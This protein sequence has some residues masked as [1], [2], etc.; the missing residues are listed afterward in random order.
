MLETLNLTASV[1]GTN[2]RPAWRCENSQSDCH[3]LLQPCLASWSTQ[4]N[5]LHQVFQA[6]RVPVLLALLAVAIYVELEFRFAWF[7]L[8]ADIFLDDEV[9]RVAINDEIL[10][11]VPAFQEENSDHDWGRTCLCHQG[12]SPYTLLEQLVILVRPINVDVCGTTLVRY[13]LYEGKENCY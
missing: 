9:L 11:T 6:K 4:H 2:L 8:L 7:S 3:L 13:L 5:Q 12:G 1:P 10:S